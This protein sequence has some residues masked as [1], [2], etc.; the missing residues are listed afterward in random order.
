MRSYNNAKYLTTSKSG[1]TVTAL[2]DIGEVHD[3]QEEEDPTSNELKNV[4]VI[5][6]SHFTKKRMC[7]SCKGKVDQIN[8]KIGKCTKCSAGQKMDKCPLEMSAT[9]LVG[10]DGN[11]RSL[12]IF[13]PMIKAILN[14]DE[15]SENE[16]EII[17]GLLI[18]DPFTVTFTRANTINGVYR[19]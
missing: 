18:A 13:L 11:T 6:I 15:I 3:K 4:E 16:E 10:T 1:F 14:T 7:I 5:T 12:K 19:A 9:L 17:E 8:T 2:D